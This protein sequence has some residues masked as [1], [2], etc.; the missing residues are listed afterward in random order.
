MTVD[1]THD[2]ELDRGT[3][4]PYGGSEGWAQVA[5]AINSILQLGTSVFLRIDVDGHEPLFIDLP[6]GL[7]VGDGSRGLPAASPVRPF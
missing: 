4:A 1:S 7:R 2:T 3:E 5:F 6:P